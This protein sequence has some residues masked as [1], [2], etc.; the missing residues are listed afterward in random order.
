MIV[1]QPKK[2]LLVALGLP[3]LACFAL[4]FYLLFG[5]V[6]TGGAVG[7]FLLAGPL[8][9][10]LG[11]WLLAMLLGR[12]VRLDIDKQQVRVAYLLL[13]RAVKIYSLA[14]LKG[15]EETQVGTGKG[16]VYR[17]LTLHLGGQRIHVGS[18]EH[19]G[20][21]ALLAF[22]QKQRIKYISR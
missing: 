18:A 11:A 9:L 5:A 1:C 6:G 7:W 12:Y 3:A 22:L 13:P 21:G 14:Q 8:L 19:E 20:Y 10:V 2:V 17:R 16:G 15:W 4:F